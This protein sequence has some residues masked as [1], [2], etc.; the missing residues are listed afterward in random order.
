MICCFLKTIGLAAVGVFLTHVPFVRAIHLDMVHAVSAGS[1]KFHRGLRLDLLPDVKFLNDGAPVCEGDCETRIYTLTFVIASDSVPPSDSAWK[2]LQTFERRN[3]KFKINGVEAIAV[4]TLPVEGYEYHI[5]WRITWNALV[6]LCKGKGFYHIPFPAVNPHDYMFQHRG[7]YTVDWIT[8]KG[9]R[10]YL[11]VSRQL[12]NAPCVTLKKGNFIKPEK[13][14]FVGKHY[15]NQKIGFQLGNEATQVPPDIFQRIGYLFQLEKIPVTFNSNSGRYEFNCLDILLLNRGVGLID[16]YINLS[17][18]WGGDRTQQLDVK[19]KG[20]QSI[21]KKEDTCIPL[22]ESSGRKDVWVL[23]SSFL[24]AFNLTFGV[25]E[26]E[27]AVDITESI[28]ENVK[29][30]FDNDSDVKY[31]R[32]DQ[33]YIDPSRT[34]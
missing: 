4:L 5:G 14:K 7:I 20:R 17:I 26:N 6:K 11:G 2:E 28:K 32:S 31:G 25:N 21:F 27:W 16:I 33:T 13:V 19:F 18:H 12:L 30:D 10:L 15:T 29:E 24:R 22:F 34:D 3:R 23:G 8:H 1:D 9:P